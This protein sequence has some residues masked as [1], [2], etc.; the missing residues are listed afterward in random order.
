M[1]SWLWP[2]P[3]GWDEFGLYADLA[4]K[5]VNQRFRWIEPGTFLMGSPES[6]PEHDKDEIQHGV[7]L[8]QGY[9][10]ADTACSQ[11]LWQ[12]VM[13]KNPAVFQEDP[14]NPVEHVSWNDTQAFIGEL[15]KLFPG[16]QACLPTEAQWEYACR[17]GTT[18]PFSFGD[19][20]TPEKVNYNGEYPYAD[21][22]KGLN[23]EK[24]VPVKSLPPNAWGFYEMHGNVWEWCRDWYGEY[25]TEAVLDPMGPSE[26]V[27]RVLRGGSWFSLG[28]HARSARRIH[29]E[30]DLRSGIIGF[31]LALGQ[32]EQ[33]GKSARS[34]QERAGGGNLGQKK[35]NKNFLTDILVKLKPK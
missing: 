30:P 1:G 10:L 23:R 12:A 29:L 15:N 34:G 31:R 27:S 14:S 6:E 25:P 5:K 8:T 17:A 19:N 21:G 33:A 32:P 3:F 35:T 9:W 4:I 24:T 18:T 20:I 2:G 16:L 7:T 11:A 13:G 22:E 26:G 28:R